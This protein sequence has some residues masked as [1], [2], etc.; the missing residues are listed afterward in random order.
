MKQL[1]Y[2]LI[3]ILSWSLKVR[4]DAPATHGMVL[5]G[6]QETYVSHLPMYHEPHN[7]QLIMK[8]SLGD[9]PGS[10]GTT[11][12]KYAGTK[13]T[14]DLF[15]IEPQK[16]DL[17]E[18]IS[19]KKTSFMAHLYKGHFEK[20]GENFG[21]VHVVIKKIIYSQKLPMMPKNETTYPNYLI[22]GQNG[23][24]FAS[25]VIDGG[26]PNYDTIVSV[27]RPVQHYMCKRVEPWGPCGKAWPV[28][29]ES[30]PIQVSLF[31]TETAVPLQPG[32]Q[33]GFKHF[34]ISTGVL[35]TIYFDDADLSH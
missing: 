4:A 6:K 33:L 24:Y 30:L 10:D 27:S 31:P 25:H 34:G 26:A 11:L 21:L 15:T 1:S 22:F 8:V 9:M 29:D 32:T 13:K 23:E 5:F 28:S 7:Y 17:T 18:I 3:S 19:G 16:M 35:K 12:D 2:I 14:E 20:G